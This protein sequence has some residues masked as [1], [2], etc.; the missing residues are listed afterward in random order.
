MELVLNKC[1]GGYGLSHAAKMKI[2]EK[3]G[4][5]VFPYIPIESD[6][7]FERT[8]KRVSEK[9]LIS[10]N[11]S[12]FQNIYYF[13]KDPGK[14]EFDINQ[15][16]EDGLD[17]NEFDFDNVERFDKVLVE[18]IKELSDKA[19]TRFSNLK[20]VEIP[21]GAEFEISDYDGVETAHFGFQTGS[22]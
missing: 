16:V 5:E 18:T 8:L 12:I 2:L 20:V 1:Y 6:D 10:E 7:I 21:D 15:S 17:Y 11:R 3:K 14:D 9:E 4:V 19:N 13:Q 22:V